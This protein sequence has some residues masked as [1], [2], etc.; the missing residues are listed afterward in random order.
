VGPRAARGDKPAC[1]W[2]EAAGCLSYLRNATA[3]PPRSGH[4]WR[5][6]FGR[7]PQLGERV[8]VVYL[9]CDPMNQSAAYALKIN[10]LSY[11]DWEDEADRLRELAGKR[12]RIPK[13]D[14]AR[15]RKLLANL[16]GELEAIDR[17]YPGLSG[18]D[19][20]KVQCTRDLVVA[21]QAGLTETLRRM[22]D[23]PVRQARSSNQPPVAASDPA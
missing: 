17:V 23:R 1:R 22:Q 9:A 3:A 13:R 19:A 7:S 20:V 16:G 18:L 10:G 6:E 11:V 15:V 2:S 14:I 8:P 21:L 4:G 12:G 5:R